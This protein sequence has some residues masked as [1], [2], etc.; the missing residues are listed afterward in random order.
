MA[1][2]AKIVQELRE[3]TGAGMMIVNGRF[4]E[5]EGDLEKAIEALRKKGCIGCQESRTHNQ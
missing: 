1:I 4:T 2:T 3:K 5:T